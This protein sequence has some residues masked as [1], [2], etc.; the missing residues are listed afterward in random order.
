MIG[1]VDRERVGEEGGEGEEGDD[2]AP[3]DFTKALHTGLCRASPLQYCSGVTH[4]AQER[5]ATVYARQQIGGELHAAFVC[6]HKVQK[7]MKAQTARIFV[8]EVVIAFACTK[9]IRR[10]CYFLRVYS[11]PNLVRYTNSYQKAFRHNHPHS[12][13]TWHTKKHQARTSCSWRNRQKNQWPAI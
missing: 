7:Q 13:T 5:H 3:S 4:D 11:P 12:H 6:L 9:K 10:S 8:N 1:I 2:S